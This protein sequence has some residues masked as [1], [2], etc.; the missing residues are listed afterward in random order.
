MYVWGGGSEGQLGIE[1]KTECP[2]PEKLP[3]D[4]SVICIAS[5]YYHTAIV[6]GMCIGFRDFFLLCRIVNES[7]F[8]CCFIY[9]QPVC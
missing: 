1:G 4:D 5:G 3:M 8:Q 9:S 2:E 6:T 7:S